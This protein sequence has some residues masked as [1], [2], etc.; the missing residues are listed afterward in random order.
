MM[1]FLLQGKEN[2][3]RERSKLEGS[4]QQAVAEQ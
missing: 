2:V 3:E 4:R 1:G